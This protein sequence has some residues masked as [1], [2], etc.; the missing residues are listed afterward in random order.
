MVDLI[1]TMA[2]ELNYIRNRLQSGGV[3][4][5]LPS[6]STAQQIPL[7]NS[8][9]PQDLINV[10]DDD[11]D[12]EDED[13]D[14]SD[15][16]SSDNDDDDN[17]DD[18]DDESSNTDL[19]EEKEKDVRVINISE[20]LLHSN[21]NPTDIDVEEI[22]SEELNDSELDDD[23]EN[24]SS[25]ESEEENIDVVKLNEF[26][27]ESTDFE[28]ILE[29]DSNLLKSIHMN[30]PTNETIDYKKMSLNRLKEIAL[31]KGLIGENSKATKNA[32]LKLLGYE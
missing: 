28:P 8:P 29:V 14:E 23:L 2:E 22:P 20:S 15:E 1:S 30:F 24:D 18:D 13:D 19:E 32:I 6:V 26:I 9:P 27:E 5:V 3:V 10:S 12:S 17:D 21:D 31:A 4:N 25:S 7:F 16:E 11:D